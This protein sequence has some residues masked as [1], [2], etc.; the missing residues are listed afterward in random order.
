LLDDFN[1]VDAD[2]GLLSYQLLAGWGGEF[3]ISPEGDQ[4]AFSTPTNV[5][6][7]N[8]DGSNWRS[9]FVYDLVITYS[10]YR[11]YAAP[12]WSPDGSYLLMA[13]PPTDPLAEPSE[14]TKL[15]RIDVAS[16]STQEIGRVDSVPFFDTPVLY[17]PDLNHIAYLVSTGGLE[18]NRRLLF[19]ASP[20][21]S[22]SNLYFEGE[23]LHFRGWNPIGNQFGFNLGEDQELYLGSLNLPAVNVNPPLFGVIDMHWINAEQF[24][25][26]QG[27]GEQYSLCLADTDGANLIIDSVVNS[28]IEFDYF[29]K[30]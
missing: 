27:I 30:N 29:W 28:R 5:I 7:A 21:G 10:D 16:S 15:L 19:F 13:L 6:L 23:M 4:V 20:D 22:G 18:E 11:Y 17:S 8:L 3:F 9:V 14:P 1:L 2:T 12:V 24:I 25:Y 26:L